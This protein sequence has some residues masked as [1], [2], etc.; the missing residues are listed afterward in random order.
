MS[1][2][3]THSIIVKTSPERAYK[4]WSNFQN[5]P[6]FMDYIK[7]VEKLGDGKSRWTVAG[8]LG[9]SVKWTAELTRNE[10]N[11]RI[12][13]NTKDN[14]GLVTTSGQ[15]TFNGLPHGETEVNATFQ[16]DLPGGAVGDAIG[17]LFANPQKRVE[18]DMR[19]YKH[20]LE[21]MLDRM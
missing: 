21:G 6:H 15:V 20:Y 11:K 19:H 8:P 13:W 18:N 16:Y 17:G 14:S 4:V 9:T 5:F 3:F 2:K 12:G 1:E 10:P 7:S